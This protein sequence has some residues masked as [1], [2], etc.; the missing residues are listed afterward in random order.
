MGDLP[1][2]QSA[3]EGADALW[4]AFQNNLKDFVS[5]NGGQAEKLLPKIDRVDWDKVKDVLE[6]NL[7]LSNLGCQ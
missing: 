3:F 1:R 2:N 6:G 7:P 5:N 4:N